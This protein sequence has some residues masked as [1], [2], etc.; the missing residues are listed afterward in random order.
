MT[1]AN[2]DVERGAPIQIDV[3]I[4]IRPQEVDDPDSTSW[5]VVGSGLMVSLRRFVARTGCLIAEL[6]QVARSWLKGMG[7]LPQATAARIEGIHHS[8]DR[9]EV[10]RQ[11]RHNEGTLKP[12]QHSEA[13]AHVETIVAQLE[14]RG[15]SVR[16]IELQPGQIEIV[17]VRPELQDA[18]L[19]ML[20]SDQPKLGTTQANAPSIIESDKLPFLGG[21]F[22]P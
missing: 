11:A 4:P 13:F 5:S 1:F 12:L 8:A 10:A 2:Q 21:P 7:N 18:M 22:F 14:A 20:S 15:L 9:T 6:P 19:G 17:A 3:F 16:V